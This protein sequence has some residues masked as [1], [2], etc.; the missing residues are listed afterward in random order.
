MR[1]RKCQREEGPTT[2]K[3]DRIILLEGKYQIKIPKVPNRG[4]RDPPHANRRGGKYQIKIP[5]VP[6]IR[7]R[8]PTTCKLDKI[9]LLGM[10]VS[11]INPKSAEER[12]EGTHHVQAG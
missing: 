6:T 7:R 5:K 11:N 3:L 10:K 12:E 4:R 2:C 1:L 9:I 8:G